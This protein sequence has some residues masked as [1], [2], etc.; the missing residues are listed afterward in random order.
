MSMNC[1]ES[2]QLD[3][4]VLVR[5]QSP[6]VAAGPVQRI[7]VAL[8]RCQAIMKESPLTVIGIS[9]KRNPRISE[10]TQQTKVVCEVG[11]KQS[12]LV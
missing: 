1:R 7:T 9:T 6:T 11:A 4:P 3:S 2:F 10:V 5:P 12:Y 8:T